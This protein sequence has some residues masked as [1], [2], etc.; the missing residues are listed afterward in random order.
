VHAQPVGDTE[1]D[2]LEERLLRLVGRASRTW[3]LIEPGDHVLVAVS[4]GKDSYGLLWLLRLLQRRAPFPFTFVAVNLD[5]GHPGFEV[6]RLRDWLDGEGFAHH[7]VAR[8][9]YTIVKQR[10]PEGRTMC[11]LCSR[12]RR[13][14][15]YDVARAL[16]CS[17]I[18][19]GHHRD[20]VIETLLL[21]LFYAGSVKAMAPLLR[22]QRDRVAV[23]RPL[24]LVDEADLAALAATRAFPILPCDLCGAQENLRRKAMK[25]LIAQ[26]HADN[27]KVRGNLFA[28]LSNVVPS[29]LLD[30][31][32]AVAS[33]D[34]DP[35]D[36]AHVP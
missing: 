33:A 6:D 34:G 32:L 3:S 1:I 23:I 22:A 27:P 5:Q 26:L 11:S 35:H 21:N 36:D 13:G 12:L 14:I 29:H 4:G 9:T 10:I 19:L 15:L 31:R 18:A 28:A 7:L 2:R 8:D 16:G 30:P 24:V 17:K 25:R 20:D